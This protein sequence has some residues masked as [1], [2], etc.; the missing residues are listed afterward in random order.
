MYPLCS[1]KMVAIDRHK[2]RL[3]VSQGPSDWYKFVTCV[4]SIVLMIGLVFFIDRVA[5]GTW[6]TLGGLA[7]LVAPLLVMVGL[8]FSWSSTEYRFDRAAGM[9]VVGRTGPARP[10]RTREVPFAAVSA[11]VDRRSG[12]G[13]AIEL[14]L[15]D[16]SALVVARAREAA[17]PELDGVVREV[18]DLLRVPVELGHGAVVADRFEIEQLVGHGGMGV[19]YRALDRTTQQKVALKLV[20]A[21]GEDNSFTE[22]FARECK[23]LQSFDHPRIARHVA[24]GTTAEGQA[25]L[26][27]QWLDGE[28]LGAA[29]ER[30]ALSLSDCLQ[31][32]L[33]AAEA[34]AQVHAKGVVHRDLKPSNLFLPG[35]S[36][37]DL[38]LLDFGVA[39]GVES[40]TL[41]TATTKLVGTPHYMS[42]EQAS[43]SRE[44]HPAA[45]IFSLGCIFYECLTGIR[46]FEAPQLFG[47]LARILYDDPTPVRALRAGVPEA[48][49]SLLSRMLAKPV[50]ARPA[51]G[52]AVLRELALLPAADGSARE[53]SA[54]P[55][56][57]AEREAA[58]Q[59]L[60]C[61]V[62][63]TLPG[64]LLPERHAERLDSTRTAAQRFGCPI[65]RLADG[66]LLATVLPKQSATDQVRIAARCAIYLAEQLPEAR[67][68]VA[69]GRAPLGPNTRVGDAVDRAAQLL[70][71]TLDTDAQV[72]GRRP[73]AG[74]PDVRLDEVAA[75]LLDSRFITVSRSGV[76]LLL[77]EQPDL[78]ESRPLLGKPTPCVGRE[79]ELI[80][81][82]GVLASSIEEGVPKAAT[83]MGPPGFGKSRLRHELIRRLRS[84]YPGSALLI[85][86]G[87]P[88]SAG[89]P[90][91]LLS[92]A[93]R[94]HAGIRV[95][96]EPA[97][98]RALIVDELCKHV[99]AEH[100]RRIS[101]FL[102]EAAGVPFPAEESPP[103]SAARGDHRVMSEQI[104]LAFFDWLAAE[105]RAHPVIL[106]LEDLQWGDAL[107]VKMLETALRDLESGSLFVLALGRPET[108][109]IFPKLFGE[110]RDFSLSLRPLST[111]ASELLVREV[112]GSEI[113]PESV[114][115]I[116]RLAAG[117]ALFLEELIRAAA[118]GKAGDVPETVLAVLQARLS[119]LSPEPRLVLRA[120]SVLGETFWRGGVGRI[121]EAWGLG[122]DPAPLLAELVETELVAQL[123][124]S[125]FPD[126]V[127]YA[128][129][130]AL[131]CDAA[132][133]LL[134]EADRRTGHLAAGQWLESVGETDGIVLARH[135]VEA[136]DQKRALA[137]YTR[138]AER[139]LELYDFEEALDRAE[140]G[141][142][143]GAEGQALGV[144][145]SIRSSAFYSR[146]RWT[147]SAAV[148]LSALELL[149]RAGSYWC[150]TVEILMQVL[151]NVNDFA[152]HAQLSDELH[153]IVP[154]PD[155]R[156]AY[157]R[158]VCA[159]V[160]GYAIS[161]A[162]DKGRACLDLIDKLVVVDSEKD[163]VARGYARLWRAVFTYI[164]GD[165]PQA[166]LSLVEKAIQDLGESQVLYRL[167]L[168]HIIKSFCYWGLG[169]YERSE[170]CAREG[171]KIAA[172]I[173]DSYHVGLADWYLGLVLSER[174]EPEL[175]DEAD[176]CARTM[177]KLNVSPIFDVVARSV[178][179]RVA[180]AKKEWARA[181]QD[182]RQARDG[183][184][185]LLP[186]S[187]L[188][189][190]ALIEALLAQKRAREAA[191]IA[192]EDLEALAKLPCP[193]NTEVLFYVAAAEALFEAGDRPEA[194]RTLRQAL[195]RI[196]VR[197]GKITEPALKNSFL[198]RR[199][200]NRRAFELA[201]AWFGNRAS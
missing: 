42:P 143:C 162:Y 177:V 185:T 93:L 61:V 131:V 107:T 100:K 108:E 57:V 75:R 25:Y 45:D 92:D 83:V 167:S 153:A 154:A 3:I 163:L 30:G 157:L 102:G 43:S 126:E 8:V 34:I 190:A 106:V 65:E 39:R 135:A 68:A 26:A 52:A 38:L 178:S 118:E 198:T 95:S 128:F 37:A 175:L 119:R 139:S 66:S 140:K 41:L 49:S 189:S 87:D 47:V 188:A 180:L 137:F 51:D 96:D 181:E 101:E 183:M 29:L 2:D 134:T 149:P 80:Q 115:R 82:E 74:P 110:H 148:G 84:L 44:I 67:I 81:L 141:M 62:L 7:T 20:V 89:S 14:L 71:R 133:G 109:E 6:M 147:D 88:L 11:V 85:G 152:R 193:V 127:E 174:S 35:N 120:A 97:R 40:S 161:A 138:A 33:A 195:T 13:R 18:S 22:R 113:R 105:C 160:L 123:R 31:V 184:Q 194:E 103:L 53:P 158:A 76:V 36:P 78:D 55:P 122:V 9:L 121:A 23:L 165:D 145:Q 60:V 171:R 114:E 28:D 186:Y 77:N 59:V 168:A 17:S 69:I 98:A 90:Y 15:A 199:R 104:A 46:P 164:V 144:L 173:H 56:A 187:L 64:D 12:D 142:D 27:M 170:Q 5:G 179:A 32:V 130:H 191:A 146:G 169:D 200:E 129:R 79:L 151:P 16:R 156:P 197:A 63:A 24:H 124:T 172:Q 1:S 116:V 132:N 10:A 21:T 117:N 155:A 112:L 166:S 159:Q 70:A 136:G 4:W 150:S 91:V 201:E 50:A 48:W 111:K 54:R 73:S 86:Y 125:R 72:S 192:R 19:V 58:D 94:R 99:A 196:E 182:G 176:E